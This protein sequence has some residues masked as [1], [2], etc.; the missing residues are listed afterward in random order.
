MSGGRRTAAPC[1]LRAHRFFPQGAFV[2][3]ILYLLGALAVFGLVSHTA[4]GAR[5]L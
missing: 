4:K 3:D 5:K 2:Q 1:V